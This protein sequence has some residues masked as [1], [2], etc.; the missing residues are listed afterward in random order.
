MLGKNGA[1]FCSGQDRFDVAAGQRASA[2]LFADEGDDF[3]GQR[4]LFDAR[5]SGEQ[6][7]DVVRPL[8]GEERNAQAESAL[9]LHIDGEK[10]W[11][12]GHGD[13]ELATAQGGITDVSGEGGEN[14]AGDAAVAIGFTRAEDGVGFID[15]DY[16]WPQRANGHEDAALLAFGISDPLGA[17][18]ANLHH[19]Q[20][21]LTGKA[22]DQ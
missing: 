13:P 7:D 12:R 6:F 2:D 10:V 21:A 8:S 9:A 1:L 4:N 5:Y 17:E 20:A 18:I 22:I 11:T 3:L 14:A 15:H 16:D 19:R